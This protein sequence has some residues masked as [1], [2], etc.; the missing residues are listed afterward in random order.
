MFDF[1]IQQLLQRAVAMLVVSAVHGAALAAAARSLGDRGPQYDGRLTINP[2]P[3]LDFV[4]SLCLLFWSLGW[5]APVRLAEDGL[6]GRHGFAVRVGAPLV[7]VATTF[8]FAL[9]LVRV[10]PF[11]TTVL[12][13]GSSFALSSV[14][15]ATADAALLFA[16]VNLI[17]LP[18]F[19]GRHLLE[20]LLPRFR[21]D[22]GRWLFAWQIAFATLIVL[23]EAT[24][25]FDPASEALQ[26]LFLGR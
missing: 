9:V 18:P 1:T 19:S 26:G 10:Q 5:I 6:T 12:P 2:L 16:L 20:A 8:A 24:N 23:G 13:P 11:L 14:L 22:E 4:G 21:P 25:A 7:A 17:P 15:N 3:H